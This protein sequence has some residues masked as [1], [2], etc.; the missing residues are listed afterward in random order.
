MQIDRSTQVVIGAATLGVAA[1]A[2]WLIK[3]AMTK[4]SSSCHECCHHSSIS[5]AAPRESLLEVETS[6]VKT[7]S[8]KTIL[9]SLARLAKAIVL[10][11][12]VLV[13][14]IAKGIFNLLF[15]SVASS[16]SRKKTDE[17]SY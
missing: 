9:G 15:S 14:F 16:L 5:S 17:V 3:N 4:E 10:L 6:A 2:G 11:P 12:F 1:G 7:E 8:K 13:A